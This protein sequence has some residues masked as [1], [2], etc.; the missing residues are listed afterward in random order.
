MRT[1]GEFK[2][3][4]ENL[5]E[6]RSLL[7]TL[8]A[9]KLDDSTPVWFIDEFS[10]CIRLRHPSIILNENEFPDQKTQPAKS[11]IIRRIQNSISALFIKLIR[12]WLK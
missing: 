1:L 7:T 10:D 4:L 5:P 6:Q 2:K 8:S 3:Q 9:L 11:G 12:I